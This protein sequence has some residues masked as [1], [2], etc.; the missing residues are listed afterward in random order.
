M[1]LVLDGINERNESGWWRTLI[2]KLSASPWSDHVGIVITCRSQYWKENFENLRYLKVQKYELS[3]YDEEELTRALNYCKL[4]YSN[5][6]NLAPLIY[7]PRYF[8]LTVK[9]YQKISESGDVT[10]ARLIYED[11]KD[12]YNRK[13]ISL[14]DDGF[15]YLIQTLADK[16]VEKIPLTP[17][18]I[19]DSL[20]ISNYR[21]EI[22]EEIKTGG[23]LCKKNGKYKVK[24]DFLSYGLALL[25]I[26]SLQDKI[27]QEDT[28]S[29]N[30]L[31]Y[32]KE[33]IAGWLEPNAGMDIKA[34]IC[35]FASLIALENADISLQIKIALLS[36]WI[37]N[38]NPRLD[39]E[40]EFILV[41]RQERVKSSQGKD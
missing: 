31:E 5:V 40:Y 38:Q 17:K 20:P 12:R 33:S 7:K 3:P 37:N 18:S 10:I 21:Q 15:N 28:N 13:K 34:E 19:E 32:L 22:F 39:S 9:Y 14:T 35:Q 30:L 1:I 36:T 24:N 27:D 29:D 26:N 11:W 6:K 8:D 4:P 23:I 41:G 2:E 25:L 16:H